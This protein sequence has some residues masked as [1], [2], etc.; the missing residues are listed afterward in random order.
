[1]SAIGRVWRWSARQSPLAWILVTPI[2]TVPLT[3]LIVFAFAQD[4]DARS[5]GLPIWRNEAIPA[6]LYYF[7]FWPT[8]LLVTMPGVLNLLVVLWF[9]QRSGYVRVAA[10]FA[11]ALGFVRNFVVVLVYFA[12]AQSDVIAHEGGLLIRLEVENRGIISLTDHS[13]GTGLFR[14]LFTTWLFGMFAWGLTVLAWG[15]YNLGMDRLLPHLKPP[16]R[17]QAGEPRSWGG[18]FERR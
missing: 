12:M 11:L 8:Y 1:M 17:R 15:L 16:K 7:D 6:R 14:M 13:P 3:A 4:L 18:F 2:L 10:G 5:L 9:F